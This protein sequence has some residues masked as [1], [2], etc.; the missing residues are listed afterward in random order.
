MH[1]VSLGHPGGVERHCAEFLA[2]ASEASPAWRHSVVAAGS[3]VHPLIR[4]E[5]RN[6]AALDHEKYFHGVKLP[7]KPRLFRRKRL[8]GI[9]AR[10]APA[11]ALIWNRPVRS[12]QFVAALRGRPW[13]YWEHGAGWFEGDEALR[14]EFYQ[15]A[16]SI[17]ANSFAAKRMLQ[18]RW[19]CMADIEVCLN[20]LR[21]GLR[22]QSGGA[23]EVRVSPHNRKI[24]LGFAGR[25]LDIKGVPL[26]LHAVG[27]L[28]KQGVDVELHVAGGGGLETSLKALAKRLDIDEEVVWHGVVK[29]MTGFYRHIDC[30]LHPAL[31]EPFGLVCIEAAAFGCPVIA[32]NIDGLPEAVSDGVTG[33]CLQPELPVRDYNDLG[34]NARELPAFVYYPKQDSIGA[35]MLVDPAEMA[36]AVLRIVEEPG[37]FR[38]LSG[39]GL[40]EID[41]KFDFGRHVD[42]V[43]GVL[44]RYCDDRGRGQ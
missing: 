1:Y 26:V 17:I 41:R 34:G 25:L 20:A 38:R 18:L 31:R 14:R 40:T 12:R 6:I 19:E 33:I 7:S 43:L 24:R 4:D 30:L 27:I 11:L 29:D 8:E 5:I 28:K 23:A 13:L 15:S 44:N 3:D 16:D 37:E 21:P 42:K 9:V 22:R 39:N 2:Y 35:P 32:A 36:A 10:R